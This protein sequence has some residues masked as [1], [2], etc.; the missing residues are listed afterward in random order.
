MLT[1][2]CCAKM[3]SVAQCWMN[4]V[5]GAMK[6]GLL[7]FFHENCSQRS[8][9][10][11]REG[12]VPLESLAHSILT[13]Y[14]KLDLFNIVTNDR[15]DFSAACP[16]AKCKLSPGDSIIMVQVS[17][18]LICLMLWAILFVLDTVGVW[19]LA[20]PACISPVVF[21]G[22]VH[23]TGWRPGQPGR[24]MHSNCRILK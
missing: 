4:L 19:K 23:H 12:D 16:W 9:C 17:W 11:S 13:D 1:T 6:Q 14:I 20:P 7:F 21:D 10:W 5:I 8:W 3:T 22:S 24:T 15:A 2:T 18:S